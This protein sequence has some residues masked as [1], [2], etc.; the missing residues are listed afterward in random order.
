MKLVALGDSN[1]GN[2]LDPYYVTAAQTYFKLVADAWGYDQ[3]IN[4]G[5]SGDTAEGMRGRIDSHVLTHDPEVCL[6]MAGTNDADASVTNNTP[7]ET[8]VGDY[9]TSMAGIIDALRTASVYPV[10]ISPGFCLRAR[11]EGRLEAMR[12][13]LRDLCRKKNVMFIDLFGVMK[14]DSN[15][16][17]TSY[18]N[19]WF[20]DIGGSPDT[21]H[22]G[23]TGHTRIAAL[24]EN[25]VVPC[26]P[27]VEGPPEPPTEGSTGAV[28]VGT[29]NEM[30]GNIS[31]K[32]IKTRIPASE[33]SP[34]TGTVT[35]MR[36]KLFGHP[37]EPLSLSQVFVGPAAA[38]GDVWDAS[39][40]SQL[41]FS[42]GNPVT[43]PANGGVWSD[44]VDVAWNKTDDLIVSFYCPDTTGNSDALYSIGSVSGS[45][46]ALSASDVSS[47]ANASGLTAY[48]GYLSL[49]SEIETDGFTGS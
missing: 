5:K 32:S 27:V 49:V 39:F 21:Y 7:T 16:K 15:S 6:V 37:T 40:L 31:T 19:Q 10:I 11:C 24:M 4:A 36:F 38:S 3:A 9:I 22:F 12:D 26:E 28:F 23:V 47:T 13:A 35:K 17:T 44:W 45:M 14:D 8:L 41:K 30:F 25:V 2:F 33:L 1:T 46:T 18:F 20:L 42:G 34:P 29:Q 48:S 43:V